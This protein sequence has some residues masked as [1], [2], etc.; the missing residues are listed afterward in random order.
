MH[1]SST[2]GMLRI[3][4]GLSGH[5]HPVKAIEQVCEQCAAGLNNAGADLLVVF[6]S[7]HHMDAARAISYALRR[8]LNPKVLLGVSGEA[9]LGGERE[10][11]QAPGISVFA[12]ALPGVDIHVFRTEMLMNFVS[13][14]DRVG[15]TAAAGFA[16]NSRATFILADPFSVPLNALL[17]ALSAVRP[18]PS[19]DAVRP[20]RLPIVG[21]MAS[22]AREPGKN[23]L[24]LDDQVLHEG[25]VGVTLSGRLRV[26]TLV[27]QG[28]RPVGPPMVLTGG[29][30]QIITSLA[31]KSALRSITEVVEELDDRGKHLMQR[32]GLFLGRAVNEYKPRFGRDDFLIRPIL[33]VDRDSEA[34]AVG[35]LMRIGQTVQLHVRD[36]ETA[37]EDLEMLL[38]KQRLH[39]PATGALLFTCNGRGRRMFSTSDHDAGAIARAFVRARPGE[40]GAK[41]G[42]T[43]PGG[44][45]TMPVAGFF[46][47]GEIG[48]LGD[49]VFVHG[50]TASAAFFRPVPPNVPD[51]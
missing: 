33:S 9:V 36:A 13:S 4:C 47:G 21:G 25:G 26:D 10:I 3:A 45:P 46:A 11:E 42:A 15:L 38:D 43:L 23:T 16:G 28:C 40:Q 29:K 34:I 20:M 27:S 51:V 48:P 19:A 6:F 44:I 24:L 31:G 50:H 12:A 32:G 30:G 17:P 2:L 22:A 37:H 49:E 14:G 8:R 18:E 1:S 7:A 39:D 5:V 35:D 41:G